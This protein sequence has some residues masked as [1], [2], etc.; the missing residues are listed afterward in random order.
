MIFS[1]G[2]DFELVSFQWNLVIIGTILETG[3]H[4]Y[5]L[6]SD[7]LKLVLATQKKTCIILHC[8]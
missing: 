6:I 4:R 3:W 1:H 5:H 7:G 2:F 8:R